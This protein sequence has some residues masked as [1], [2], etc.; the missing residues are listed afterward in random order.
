MNVSIERDVLAE[1][2][3]LIEVSEVLADLLV[4]RE[5]LGESP[6]VVDFGDVELVVRPFGIDA[7]PRVSIPVPDAT[8]VSARFDDQG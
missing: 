5:A 2:E 8:E 3:D 6:G 7:G 1:V 4:T